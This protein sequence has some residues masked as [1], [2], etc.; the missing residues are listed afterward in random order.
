MIPDGSLDLKD[1]DPLI[2]VGERLEKQVYTIV[3]NAGVVFRRIV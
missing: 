2:A 1:Q 3:L